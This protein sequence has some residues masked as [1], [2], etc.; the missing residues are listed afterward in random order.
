MVKS[1][2]VS[3]DF[4]KEFNLFLKFIFKKVTCLFA[5]GYR[6]SYLISSGKHLGVAWCSGGLEQ[7]FSQGKL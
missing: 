7:E 1:N 6:E 5:Q 3:I 4:I 2:A